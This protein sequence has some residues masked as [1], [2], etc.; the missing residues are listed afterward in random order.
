MLLFIIL[1]HHQKQQKGAFPKI[2][3]E[4]IKT[5]P[6]PNVSSSQQLNIIKVVDKILLLK[7]QGKDSS[8]QEK[9]IDELVYK[10][11]DITPDEQKIIE[12]R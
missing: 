2:L 9:K 8:E 4:D 10:L 1:I 6:L 12:S 7:Q 5:F 3:V 11:Y